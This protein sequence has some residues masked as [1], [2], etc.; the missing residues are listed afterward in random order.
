MAKRTASGA[1][2][3][4]ACTIQLEDGS[5]CD[6]PMH[7]DAPFPIC[8]SHARA[9]YQ[10]GISM[11]GKVSRDDGTLN[12]RLVSGELAPARQHGPRRR[13]A[14]PGVYFLKL[15]DLIKIGASDNVPQRLKNYPPGR[16]VL[17]VHHTD[18]PWLMEARIL[19]KFRSARRSGY[20]WFEPTPEILEF[21]E[22]LKADAA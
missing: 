17:H 20:E 11:V 5:F 21:I 10:F 12:W 4:T 14:R 7:P 16:V 9:A 6:K 15:G 3:M 13:A 1:L 19:K 8:P 2:R 22:S 18:D